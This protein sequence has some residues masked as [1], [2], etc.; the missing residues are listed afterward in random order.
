MVP[1]FVVARVAF[2]VWCLS[3]EEAAGSIPGIPTCAVL[4]FGK[5]KGELLTAP[6]ELCI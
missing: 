4:D 6:G 2:Q 5:R 1:V 3:D